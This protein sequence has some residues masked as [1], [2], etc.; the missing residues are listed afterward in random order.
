LINRSVENF[1]GGNKNI[2]GLKLSLIVIYDHQGGHYLMNQFTDL[3]FLDPK[4]T[5]LNHGSFGAAPK[6][7][8]KAA[9]D[10][11][12]QLEQQP[13]KYFREAPEQLSAARKGL[14]A[15]IGSDADNLVFV[16][17][18]TYGINVIVHSLKLNPGDE[19]LTTN[20]EY[21]AMDRTWKYYARQQSFVYKPLN[22]SQPIRS[23][24][25]IVAQFKQAITP[26]TRVLYLSHITSPTAVIFPVEEICRLAKQYDLIT[27]ID[28][29]HAPGQIDLNLD[30]LGADFYTG[31]L[32]KWLCAPKGS[33]FLYAAPHMHH[34][35]EPLVISWG[36]EAE[37]P[38][39]SRFNDY[40]EW[41]GTRDLSPFL[42]V[43]RAIEFL[44][45]MNWPS[46]R[47]KA[48]EFTRSCKAEINRVFPCE[49]IIAID[50]HLW[51]QMAS[52]QLPEQ[53][54][55]EAVK[56]RIYDEFQVEVPLV[57]WNSRHLIRFSFQIYNDEADIEKLLHALKMCIS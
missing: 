8:I 6:C 22:L 19:I 16:P 5:F 45:K 4:I 3:F 40:M 34:L 49:E 21:G 11:Q 9:Q 28:G 25:E 50:D 32:H 52:V 15:Y 39:P 29:A 51:G 42:A 23:K 17:N 55:L 7:V 57:Q 38:G 33:A 36:W 14:G 37:N 54:N 46:V 53:K 18:A 10:W 43:P 27:I 12:L 31:N 44:N 30:Q 1:T 56:T 26:K 13:V 48:H 35:I 41:I 24:E 20:H 2:L 47:E